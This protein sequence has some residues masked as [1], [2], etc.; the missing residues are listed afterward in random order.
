MDNPHA[1]TVL[2]VQID[3][4]ALCVKKRLGSCAHKFPKGSKFCP[5][6]GKKTMIDVEVAVKG[7]DEENETL[8]GFGIVDGNLVAG[9]C[10]SEGHWSHVPDIERIKADMKRKLEPLGFWDEERFGV[11]CRMLLY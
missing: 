7:Y 9:W 1:R 5:E 6:C 8:G 11:Y 3:E 2:G 10:I 4:K